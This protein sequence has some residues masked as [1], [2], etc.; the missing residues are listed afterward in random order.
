MAQRLR[1]TFSTL[2]KDRYL[3][4]TRMI[5]STS[6]LSMTISTTTALMT[7][8]TMTTTQTTSTM[9]TPMV[10]MESM[11]YYNILTKLIG[12]QE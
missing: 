5:Q 6:T 12:I 9:I 1:M 7:L 3:G 2:K 8:D 11:S 4:L 10:M